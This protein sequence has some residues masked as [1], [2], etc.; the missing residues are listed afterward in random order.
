MSIPAQINFLVT[1]NSSG[2]FSLLWAK[3]LG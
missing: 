3:I 2:H 1:T